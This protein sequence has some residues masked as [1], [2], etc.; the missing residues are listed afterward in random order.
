M[1]GTNWQQTA[2]ALSGLVP[3]L[4]AHDTNGVDIYFLNNPKVAQNVRSSNDIFNLFAETRPRGSTPT[5]K[6]LGGILRAYMHELKKS[7]GRGTVKP[8]NVIVITDGS[9]SDPDLLEKEITHCARE[10]D[11]MKAKDR[12]VGIQF[13][14]VGNDEGAAQALEE[15]D[16]ALAEEHET[17][18]M[19][20]TVSFRSV[21]GVGNGL[22]A[23]G[24]LKVVLGAVDGSL[25]RKRLRANRK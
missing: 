24:V 13:F 6:R 14:Q 10:L 4:T 1:A 5:G 22:T 7:K 2:S 19:V 15:L 20:D 16:N 23:E 18:D 12:Q 11:K 8:L 21:V 17:R 25:D 9:P 3:V